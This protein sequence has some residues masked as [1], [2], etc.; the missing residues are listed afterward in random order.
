M[1][2]VYSLLA[3]AI[4]SIVLF[5]CGGGSNSWSLY[6]SGEG[7]FSVNMPG[8]PEKTDKVILT[9]FG[10]QKVNFI[11]WKPSALAIDKFKLF[12][13]SFTNCPPQYANDTVMRDYMLDSCIRMRKKD[14]TEKVDFPA[15]TI[16]LNGYPGRAFIFD[17]QGTIAIVK[18]CIVN[19]RLYDLTVIAKSEQ[20]TNPEIA[21]F[22][23]SFQ[24]L[25]Q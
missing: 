21:Q 25:L 5:S 1:R 7:G 8:K 12:Q 22:F 13:V 2:S 23:N 3:V 18:E 14:F 17:G 15:E 16:E 10:K 19:G 9:A 20:G 11:T 4:C 6:T 24:P